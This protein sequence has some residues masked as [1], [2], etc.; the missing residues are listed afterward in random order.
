MA[1]ITTSI[2]LRTKGNGP[3]RYTAEVGE[4]VRDSGISSGI[5][6]VFIPGST[7]GVT[8]EYERSHTGF[9]EA[10]DRIAPGASV[11]TTTRGGGRNGYST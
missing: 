8:I 2:R 11:I 10:I 3:R 4:S 6:T 1:V 9:Q 5:V 7:A